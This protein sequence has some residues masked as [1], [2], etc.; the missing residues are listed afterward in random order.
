MFRRRV[1]YDR[2][3]GGILLSYMG[4]GDFIDTATNHFTPELEAARLGLA[5]W[6]VFAWDEPDAEIEA[7]FS[8]C[9]EAGNPRAV[10]VAADVSASPHKLIFSYEPA[11]AESD[12]DDPYGIIDILSGEVE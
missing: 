2:A 1:F 3:G 10:I 7:Q 9:D 8:P 12:A 5:N 11:Q 4:Q 6:G